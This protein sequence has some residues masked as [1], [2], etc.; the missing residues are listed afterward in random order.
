MMKNVLCVLLLLVSAYSNITV[1]T[2]IHHIPVGRFKPSI[3]LTE[4]LLSL[5]ENCRSEEISNV[6]VLI[7][8][9]ADDGN[10]ED[11][12]TKLRNA[13][14]QAQLSS[15]YE[16][17]SIRGYNISS[18]EIK[19]DI[20]LLMKLV[21][22]VFGAQPTYADMFKYAESNLSHHMVAIL[23]ADIILCGL[24]R[25]DYGAFSVKS[26]PIALTIAVSA[27]KGC[28]EDEC[29]KPQGWSWDVHIFKTPLSPSLNYS[30]LEEVGP[31]PVYMNAMGAENRVGYMLRLGGYTLSNPCRDIIAE[32]WHCGA[33][34]HFGRKRVDAIVEDMA[35][36]KDMFSQVLQWGIKPKAITKFLWVPRCK[37]GLGII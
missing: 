4:V 16:V 33:K 35:I 13:I 10:N 8:T 11:V 31:T 23:N 26:K 5:G 19:S 27:A 9:T 28:G 20:S 12:T 17:G 25:L 18:R 21:V 1:V 29:N 6:H 22:F 14:L 36:K 37:G 24:N 30:L 7:D 2:T 34:E 3:H 32:H 15:L